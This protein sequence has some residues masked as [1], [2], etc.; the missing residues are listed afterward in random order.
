MPKAQ[1]VEVLYVGLANTT[2]NIPVNYPGKNENKFAQLKS[3]IYI[4]NL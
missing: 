1:G 3:C 4:C 2:T